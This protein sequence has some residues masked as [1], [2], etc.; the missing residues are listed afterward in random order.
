MTGKTLLQVEHVRKTY[1]SGENE[2]EVLQD[3]T[4][5]IISGEIVALMGPSGVGKTTL[6]NLIGAL[7]IPDAGNIRLQTRLL[8]DLKPDALAQVRNNMLGFVFQFHHLLPEFTALENVLIPGMIQGTSDF[9]HREYGVSL[10]KTFGLEERVNHFPHELS[11]GEKQRVALARA[12]I[13][14]PALVLA[15]EPT[16]NLDRHTGS[17]LLD[18]LIGFSREHQQTFLI[19]THDESI[20]EKADRR[21]I[22]ESGTVH[23]E[24]NSPG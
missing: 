7:D 21:L 13:N 24:P 15:D 9:E 2:L 1:R 6:L 4:F 14:H 17:R 12:L 18:A 10:L 20:A 11:G 23:E 22:L 16:G 3:I 19:A 8:S 5:E